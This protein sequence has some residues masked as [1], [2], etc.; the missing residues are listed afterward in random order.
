MVVPELDE[1]FV[2][3]LEAARS[4]VKLVLIV[5]SLKVGGFS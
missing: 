1:A 3:P 5:T 2:A 4:L